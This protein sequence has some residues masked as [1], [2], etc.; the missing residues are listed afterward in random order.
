[1]SPCIPLERL[2]NRE[3]ERDHAEREPED[4]DHEQDQE[5]G[6]DIAAQEPQGAVHGAV[7]PRLGLERGATAL[8]FDVGDRAG[9]QVSL[10]GLLATGECVEGKARRNLSHALAATGE[11]NPLL[12]GIPNR[13]EMNLEAALQPRQVMGTFASA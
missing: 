12:G 2:A 5:S 3:P 9:A 13:P 7:D 1:M 10:D 4:Q 6:D 8:G 11:L